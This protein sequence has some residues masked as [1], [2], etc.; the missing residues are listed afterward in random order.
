VSALSQ[1]S[2]DAETRD[3]VNWVLEGLL[4]EMKLGVQEMQWPE[5][6]FGALPKDILDRIVT[7]NADRDIY[8]AISP[9]A[10]TKL[11][12]AIYSFLT[13]SNPQHE[14]YRKWVTAGINW[15][16]DEATGGE[17]EPSEEPIK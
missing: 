16:K 13:D 8:D 17:E 15:M 1:E 3:R 10:D 14:F 6:A 12:E 2:I 9:W 5:K 4:R 11:M 7:A